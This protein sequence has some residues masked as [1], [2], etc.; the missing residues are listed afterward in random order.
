MKQSNLRQRPR[1]TRRIA[2]HAQQ[3]HV[4]DPYEAQQKLA[5]GTVC[6]QCGAVFHDGRW[7]WGTG[8]ERAPQELCA[9]CRR[10]TDKFPAGIVALESILPRIR[11]SNWF[12]WRAIRSRR[13][14]TSIPSTGSSAL[15]R[16]RRVW[17]SRPRTSICRAVS[18]R[19]SSAPCTVQ[20]KRISSQ[21]DTS[22]G[23][24]GRPVELDFALDQCLRRTVLRKIAS[25]RMSLFG[26]NM[27]G[28]YPWRMCLLK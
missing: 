28:R 15:R 2:G 3:D 6:P 4:L 19:R 7:R 10:I 9:A 18:P 26:F 11:K 16:M 8:E 21:M 20:S 23:W 24:I 17:L 5:E 27:K 14:R 22:F 1:S 25:G 12:G 13:R